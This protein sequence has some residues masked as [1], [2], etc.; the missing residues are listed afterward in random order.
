MFKI[1][2]QKTG[3]FWLLVLHLMPQG[4]TPQQTTVCWTQEHRIDVTRMI[5]SIIE[6]ALNTDPSI[7]D[8]RDVMGW[9]DADKLD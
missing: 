8:S 7:K 4:S 2:V 1:I 9:S 6:E 5:E 3:Y